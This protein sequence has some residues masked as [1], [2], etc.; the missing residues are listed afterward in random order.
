MFLQMSWVIARRAALAA[1][2]VLL[3]SVPAKAQNPDGLL[4]AMTRQER[5]AAGLNK[6]SAEEQ[7]Y[8]EAWLRQRLA[9]EESTQLSNPTPSPMVA[10]PDAERSVGA[11]GSDTSDAAMEAEIERRVAIEVEA[12]ISKAKEDEAAEEAAREAA[13]NE[14]FEAEIVGPFGGWSGK[15]VFTL[16]NGQVW[17]QRNGSNYR[18]TAQGQTV[19]VKKNFM[20]YWTLTVLSSGR[21]VGVRRID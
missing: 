17:R 6:L 20:G 14:P 15:T 9:V 16:S 4:G 18:H 19:A 3:V 8:L 10:L 2:T 13:L 21:T 5:E 11:A 7:R 12:A 1:L